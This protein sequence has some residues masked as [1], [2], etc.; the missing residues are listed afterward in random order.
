VAAGGNPFYLQQ[1]AR[2][3]GRT[4]AGHGGGT[5]LTGAEVPHAV[6]AALAEERALLPPGA[7]VNAGRPRSP[8]HRPALTAT[9][10][11]NAGRPRG[12]ARRPALTGAAGPPQCR[13]SPVNAARP[14][15]PHDAPRR[16]GVQR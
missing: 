7:R 5:P 2:A 10:A 16:A 15:V 1:L 3:G 8:R 11:V 6:A 9:C 13:S 4:L 14:M 12:S